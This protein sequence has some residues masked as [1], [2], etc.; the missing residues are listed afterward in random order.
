MNWLGKEYIIEKYSRRC[1]RN[2]IY[3][4]NGSFNG[5]YFAEKDH[6]ISN[7]TNLYSK[8]EYI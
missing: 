2:E 7:Y 6:I 8:K 5:H 1:E 4:T 3:R